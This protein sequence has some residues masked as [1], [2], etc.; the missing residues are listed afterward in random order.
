[1]PFEPIREH[2]KAKYYI[3]KQNC[4]KISK[5][6]PF[7][8]APNLAMSVVGDV[9]SFF[10]YVDRRPSTSFICAVARW[11]YICKYISNFRMI[12]TPFVKRFFLVLVGVWRLCFLIKSYSCERLYIT[13]VKEK[14]LLIFEEYPIRYKLRSICQYVCQT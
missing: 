1:M 7:W 12:M 3:L 4:P 10:P 5:N 11:Q 9:L 14:V 8:M 2:N 13:F 6:L